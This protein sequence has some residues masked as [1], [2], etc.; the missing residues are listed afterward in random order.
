MSKKTVL[1]FTVLITIHL[2]GPSV[3][4]GWVLIYGSIIAG[5]IVYELIRDL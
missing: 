5:S 3:W 1:F 2:L 4:A